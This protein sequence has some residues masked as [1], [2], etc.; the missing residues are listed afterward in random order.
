MLIMQHSLWDRGAS[1]QWREVAKSFYFREVLN[2]H[3]LKDNELH[4]QN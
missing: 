1:D 2:L 3:H 4:N